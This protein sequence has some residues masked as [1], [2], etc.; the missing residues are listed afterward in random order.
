MT[1]EL[2]L[3]KEELHLVDAAATR[4][5][6]TWAL[7]TFRTLVGLS[8]QDAARLLD[9]G[10]DTG[11]PV[12]VPR[13]RAELQAP[14]LGFSDEGPWLLFDDDRRPARAA[15][16]GRLL[17]DFDVITAMGWLIS[18]HEEYLKQERDRFGRWCESNSLVSAHGFS[19]T[20]AVNVWV[21]RIRDFFRDRSCDV[22]PLWPD[23]KRYA[24]ALS[25][26]I[27]NP[28]YAVAPHLGHLFRSVMRRDPRGLRHSAMKAAGAGA[29]LAAD[30]FRAPRGFTSLLNLEDRL[31]VRST[32]FVSGLTP[33]APYA[34]PNDPIYSISEEPLVKSLERAR[35]LGCA[36][37][38]HPAVAT[39]PHADRYGEQKQFVE[40]VLGRSIR[41][42]RHHYWNISREETADALEAMA[43][44]G[45]EFDSSL[46]F[47]DSP[48]F[49]RSIA[50]PFTP[51]HPRLDRPIPITE[52]P[53]TFMD[54]WLDASDPEA[55]LWAHIEDVGRLEG[56]V[57]LNW[58][59]NRF[60]N[61][62][63]L[64]QGRVYEAVVAELTRRSDVWLT[65]LES[66]G[67][68]WKARE[69][70]LRR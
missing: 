35:D 67:D 29:I 4:E 15:E 58:H 34:Q 62:R 66:V 23:G 43:Q 3:P 36:I 53:P 70:R 39:A 18:G 9:W 24:V 51:F 54:G 57:V 25:H 52:L 37:G 10:E 27:D 41:I 21:K 48:N 32:I 12:W 46:T 55:S 56:M 16:A 30:R 45:F 13:R 69:Q 40:R 68:W 61:R 28:Y 47:Y 8:R 63:Y 42:A 14:Q 38:L 7:E 6:Q 31:G 59:G 50:W 17:F 2:E 26:D 19:R 33:D 64:G 49:R 65:S 5:F 22:V 44:T 60:N 1:A 11:R 20:P